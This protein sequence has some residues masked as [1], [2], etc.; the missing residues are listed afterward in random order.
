MILPII[1]FL[2]KIISNSA[3][4][5]A[6]AI[7]FGRMLDH[8]VVDLQDKFHRRILVSRLITV[9]QVRNLQN[10]V[11]AH[12]F[13]YFRIISNWAYFHDRAIK[14]GM[15][16]IHVVVYKYAKFHRQILVRRQTTVLQVMN[17]KNHAFAII[18]SLS[19]IIFNSAWFHACAIKFGW[20]LVLVVVDK[21]DRF[22]R[23]ILARRR[24]TAL[25]VRKL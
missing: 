5:Y 10:H 19:K 25:Q 7:R 3:S 4:F 15:I 13:F 11:F 20:K 24:I 8:V 9:L 12:Y 14:F 18:R 17:L 23:E 1:S 21:H 2:S 22:R 16:L 6:H